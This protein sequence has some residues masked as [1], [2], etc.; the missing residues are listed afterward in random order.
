MNYRNIYIQI[1]AKAKR[2]VQQGIRPKNYNQKKNFPNQYFEFHHILP[3]S[4]FPLWIKR[5][6]NIVPLT[7]REHFFCHELLTKIF[8]GRSMNYALIKL[9]YSRF[10][11]PSAKQ[12]ERAK[13]LNFQNA[14][15]ESNPNY[16]H[17]WSEAQK[18][19]ASE[20]TKLQNKLQGNGNKGN[21][22]SESQK[23]T[24]SRKS[25]GRRFFTNGLT[26]IRVFPGEEPEGF[27]LGHS[28][29]F[30]PKTEEGKKS[31]SNHAKNMRHDFTK[32]KT[33]YHN[34]EGKNIL[35]FECPEGFVKGKYMSEEKLK[36]MKRKNSEAHKGKLAWNKG[37]HYS[38]PKRPGQHWYTNGK[39]TVRAFDC[40]EG[41]WIGRIL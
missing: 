41:F 29:S 25:K 33:W 2:E 21:F 31:K 4:L 13:L 32:G 20:R 40:P 22:W 9:T 37:K 16:G 11:H 10:H 24:Q 27:Y 1:L 19:A 7:A 6:S 15:G 38:L 34:Q 8:P 5:K 28:S 35:A 23:E 36:E 17:K 3:R 30:L 18:K 26:T 12:Y 39:I 14:L